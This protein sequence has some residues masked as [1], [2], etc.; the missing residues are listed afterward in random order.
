MPQ[1]NV[2]EHPEFVQS[3]DMNK[4]ITCHGPPVIKGNEMICGF[5]AGGMAIADITD[6]SSPKLISNLSWSPP[7]VGA[8]HTVWPF[9]DRDYDNIMRFIL[10][11]V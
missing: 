9:E 3:E 7:F 11:C 6:L 4:V 10:F 2:E 5:W 1:Q 8:T